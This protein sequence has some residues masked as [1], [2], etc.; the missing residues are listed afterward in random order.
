MILALTAIDLF[1]GAGGLSLGLTKA[2]IKVLLAVDSWNLAVETYARNFSHPVVQGDLGKMAG[3][4]IL[5][6]AGV[7]KGSVDLVVG[8]PPCQGFSIQRIGPDEDSRNSLVLAYGRLVQDIRP[9]M[10]IME[11]VLG[12]MGKRGSSQLKTLLSEMNAAGYQTAV[13]VVNAA[14]YG[15]PQLRKRVVVA[16]SLRGVK[17]F[18][19]PAPQ[20]L[21]KDYQT[22]GQALFNLPPPADPGS[23]TALDSLHRE[24]RLSPLNKERLRHI[25]PGGGMEDLPVQLRV[26]CHKEGAAKIG[27]RNVYGRLAPDKP[28]GTIT[29]RFDSFTRGKFAHPS[30]HRNI[31]LREG[32]RLQ[33]FPDSFVFAGNQEDIAAQ[34]GNAIPP[35][36]A[37]ALAKAAVVVLESE[38]DVRSSV[39]NRSRQL[40]LF[41]TKE[42]IADGVGGLELER[43]TASNVSAASS[44]QAI[45]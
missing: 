14:D 41:S 35:K 3:D 38:S 45:A 43:V 5:Q 24:T 18:E 33:S 29:A 10:F 9:R 39:G 31:T 40:A 42:D 7:T 11:N 19:L 34:I 44:G 2:G 23:T 13:H 32:A 28:A 36:M 26:N 27:H 22:V 30:E 1:C 37:E 15:V 4:A 16:G 12:L 8:G 21:P 17:G 25:P 6:M 20:L